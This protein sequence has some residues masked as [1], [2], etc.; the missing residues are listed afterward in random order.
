MID[1]SRGV[2]FQTID[3]EH[4]GIIRQFRNDPRIY[5]WCR[6]TTLINEIEH[7]QWWKW[8]ATAQDVKMFSVLDR[9]S[10]EILGV[11]GLTDINLIHRRAEFSLYIIPSQRR[12]GKASE[13]LKTLFDFGFKDLNLNIIWGETF[14]GNPA[15]SLFKT[16][17]MNHEGTR[18]DYY[19]KNG[20][21]ID[22]HLVSIKRSEWLK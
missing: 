21:Y 17:G 5:R 10:L 9:K 16:L 15:F 22:A 11:A 12:R 18:R 20:N 19:Y 7:E 13:A 4:V 3:Q 14:D 8:Q 2:V 1:Y 6:Q